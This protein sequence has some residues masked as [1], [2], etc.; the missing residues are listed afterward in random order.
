MAFLYNSNPVDTD[1]YTI[2][3]S[4]LDNQ[5]GVNGASTP[6]TPDNGIEILVPTGLPY[7]ANGDTTTASYVIT[8]LRIQTNRRVYV[9]GSGTTLRAGFYTNVCNF[10]FWGANGQISPGNG[11]GGG[12]QPEFYLENAMNRVVELHCANQNCTIVG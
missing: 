7:A 3:V 4:D 8:K 11:P 5:R 10:R 12:T 1:Q 2:Q 6:P 9:R